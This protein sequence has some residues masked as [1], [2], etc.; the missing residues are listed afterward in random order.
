[1]PIPTA[2]L[3][4]RITVE[5]HT[6]TTGTGEPVY[7]APMQLKARVVGK[8]RLITTAEGNNVLADATAQ[9][10]PDV[11]HIPTES[12]VTHQGRLWEAHGWAQ[13]EDLRRGHHVELILQ[14]PKP[15]QAAG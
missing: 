8:R 14:G 1:M 9:L 7:G 6:G 11:G 2:S 10:R 5:P 15:E 12:R 13:Q 3:P 4:H